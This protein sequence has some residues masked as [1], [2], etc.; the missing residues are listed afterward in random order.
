M[1]VVLIIIFVVSAIMGVVADEVRKLAEQSKESAD[2]ITALTTD[3]MAETKRV[4][5]AVTDELM[6]VETGVKVIDKAG[7]SF[8]NITGA[9]SDISTR[10]V[11]VS[12]VT[13]EISAA[14]EE[15][16][17]SVNELSS[18][19]RN[20]AG[21][22]EQISQQVEEQVASIQEINAITENL[23]KKSA[24]LSNLIAQFKL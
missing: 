22:S 15:V 16:S 8:T 13:E 11:E 6:Q 5:V 24:E 12:A 10:V 21:S 14:T 9:V 17:A 18:N 20:A 1:S 3:I 2:S 19:I 4:E 7:V 23:E